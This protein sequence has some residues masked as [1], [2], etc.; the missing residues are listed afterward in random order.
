MVIFLWSSGICK[1][2]QNTALFGNL[3]LK[4]GWNAASCLAVKV[5]Y[6][7]LQ[8]TIYSYFLKHRIQVVVWSNIWLATCCQLTL[9]RFEDCMKSS[10]SCGHNNSHLL[11]WSWSS[12][13]PRC[14]WCTHIVV[15]V[16][17]WPQAAFLSILPQLY[18][19]LFWWQRHDM[20][21][22]QLRVFCLNWGEEVQTFSESTEW[23][24]P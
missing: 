18:A 9:R 3:R 8:W 10:I 23:I 4:F 21:C 5:L 12:S 19:T 14:L 24:V 17:L 6:H 7:Y 2:Y 11:L 13:G 22:R 20:N 1:D 16:Q 15:V